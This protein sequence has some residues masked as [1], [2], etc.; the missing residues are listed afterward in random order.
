MQSYKFL[1]KKIKN[2]NCDNLFCKTLTYQEKAI[3]SLALLVFKNCV[4]FIPWIIYRNLSTA[5][6]P[7]LHIEAKQLDIMIPKAEE[8]A[9]V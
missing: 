7:I 4:Y 8:E 5:I 9:T 1:K 3:R 2:K 6:S